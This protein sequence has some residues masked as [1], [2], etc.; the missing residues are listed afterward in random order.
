[1]GES[2]Q[3]TKSTFAA[4]G[5]VSLMPEN[6][7]GPLLDRGRV[8]RFAKGELIQQRGD[9]AKEFWYIDHGII[10]IGRHS[11]DGKLTLFALLGPGE[12]FG[13]QGF[14]GEFPRMVDAIA[15]SEA[16]LI[17]I[18]EAELLAAIASDA[19]VARI[20]LKA[21]ANMVQQAFDLIDAG[22]NLSTVERVSQALLQLRSE[23]DHD[24]MIPVTQQELSDL[25]GVSRISLGKALAQMEADDLIK[26]QYGQIMV[27][28]WNALLGSNRT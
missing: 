4:A 21:M 26:R 22:R 9:T 8:R 6:V 1:M 17:E 28:D 3:N 7:R 5:F 13:E 20:M 12:S 19:S 15:G 16:R 27:R 10:Q 11:V 14:L 2:R 18:G 24:A 23:E 25:V